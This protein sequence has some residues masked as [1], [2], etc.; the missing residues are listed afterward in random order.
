MSHCR[1]GVMDG[2]RC[3]GPRAS[4]P[5]DLRYRDASC[6][7]A[8]SRGVDARVRSP[9]SFGEPAPAKHLADD[10]SSW[11]RTSISSRSV[12]GQGGPSA[13]VCLGHRVRCWRATLREEVACLQD[14]AR[15]GPSHFPP[16]PLSQQP[17]RWPPPP[18]VSQR[19]SITL[20][21]CRD[22]GDL[23]S[24]AAPALSL[25]VGG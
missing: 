7:L 13:L 25:L 11:E 14:L 10:I 16:P 17:E 4:S 23:G 15:G 21:S 8:P 9:P 1:L 12:V 2:R 22:A 5:D 18:V 3:T 24:G 6:H 19:N 20:T